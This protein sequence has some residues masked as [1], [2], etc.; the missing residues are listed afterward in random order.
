MPQSTATTLRLAILC[1]ALVSLVAP[2]LA[3]PAAPQTSAAGTDRPLV[4]AIR[5][6]AWT[7]WR[8]YQNAL[9]PKQWHSRLPFYARTLADGKVEVRGD[10]L[11]VMDREI[12]YARAAGLSYWAWCWYDTEDKAATVFHMNRCL[13]LYRTSKHR[14]DVSYCL[15][16]GSYWATRHWPQTAADYVRLFKEP[17]YQKVLG[18]RPLLYYFMADVIVAHYGSAAKAREAL[19]L[20]RARCVEAGLGP[21]YVVALSFWPDKGA[22]AM[23]DAG[24]DAMGSYCN[25][26]G[27]DGRALPYQQLAGLNRWFWNK[28]K[29]TGKPFVPS[30][31]T[32]WDYRPLI[33]PEFPDRNPKGDW[34]APPT[35]AQLADHLKGALDWVRDN[36]AICEANTVLVY[37][38]NEFAEGGW[39]CPTLEEGPARLDAIRRVLKRSAP[40]GRH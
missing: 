36:R 5:W 22:Q 2:G 28:C 26:G 11:Q 29:E 10:S 24:F 7:D 18:N 13:D 12:G 4:G 14:F 6:D 9:A 3:A 21:A 27:A 34:Y 23:D 35:P 39:L 37:A 15:I 20:L 33:G 32:G 1:Q 25:P 16:G 30:L 8:L 38:W 17:N 19:D 31:N 40:Q